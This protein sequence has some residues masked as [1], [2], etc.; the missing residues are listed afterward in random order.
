MECRDGVGNY[1]RAQA[2]GH[3]APIAKLPSPLPC[4][5]FLSLSASRRPIETLGRDISIGHTR[6]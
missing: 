1:E 5:R 3:A 2:V 6:G 4:V